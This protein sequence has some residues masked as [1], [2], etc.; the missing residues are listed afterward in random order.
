MRGIVTLRL[1]AKKAVIDESREAVER[2]GGVVAQRGGPL[3]F[4]QMVRN[5]TEWYGVLSTSSG[6]S[7]RAWS[8]NF[9]IFST[10]IN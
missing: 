5:G 1:Q 2:C 7:F 9:Y 6:L 10:W 8:F 3:N 4:R